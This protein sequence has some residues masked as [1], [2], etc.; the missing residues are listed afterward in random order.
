M[1]S[2]CLLSCIT[3][4][5]ADFIDNNVDCFICGSIII[6]IVSIYLGFMIFIVENAIQT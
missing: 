3:D 6:M 4:D 2:Q 5:N 1:L